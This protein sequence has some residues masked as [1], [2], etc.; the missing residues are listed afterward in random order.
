LTA[1]KIN[2]NLLSSADGNKEK[3]TS[4]CFEIVEKCLIETRTISHLLHPPLLDEAGFGSAAR[5]YVDGFAQRSGIKANID[6][7]PKLDRL[8]NDVEIAL[9]RALQEALTNVHRH[10]GAS[11]VDICVRVDTEQVYLEISD[12]GRG[13]PK[14]CLTHFTD[15][16]GQAGVGIAGMRERHETDNRNPHTPAE[17]G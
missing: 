6:L 16:D 15:G 12:N 2:L 8:H 11:G 10:S 4:E 1:L 3:L 17:I 7:P 9:F 14:K 5:W 13:I